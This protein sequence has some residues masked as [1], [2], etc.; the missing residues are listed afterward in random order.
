M[1]SMRLPALKTLEG[2]EFSFHLSIKREQIESLSE[3]SFLERK[4]NVVTRGRQDPSGYR[5]R[6]NAIYS[7]RCACSR[8]K[9]NLGQILS[10]P[11]TEAQRFHGINFRPPLT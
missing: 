3:L 5:L 8:Q 7:I 1:R 2:F 4:E 11:G 6:S 9:I 10:A